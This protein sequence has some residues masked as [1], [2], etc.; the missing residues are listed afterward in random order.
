M[1]NHIENI[2]TIY[3]P[4][5]EVAREVFDLLIGDACRVTFQKILPMPEVYQRMSSG[6]CPEIGSDRWIEEHDPETGAIR[7]PLTPEEEAETERLGFRT[8]RDWAVANWGTKW[9]AYG[10]TETRLD[11][12]TIRLSFWTAWSPP[13]GVFRALKA[14]YPDLEIEASWEDLDAGGGGYL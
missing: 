6:W 7:R 8:W 9:D 4:S 13:E 12:S 3:A 1:P 10:E 11:G 14:R 5:P 2:W